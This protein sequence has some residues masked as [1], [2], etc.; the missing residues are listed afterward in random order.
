MKVT[1]ELDAYK[2]FALDTMVVLVFPRVVAGTIV[3]P[4]LTL[5]SI[6]LAV[7]G[8]F[9]P[10]IPE[11]YTFKAY[12]AGV[13]ESVAMND[14]GQAL[15][16]GVVFGAIFAGLGCYHGLRTGS[17][18]DAVGRSTTRAVVSGIVAILV[19]DSIISGIFYT[20]TT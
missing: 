7:V 3:L 18:A 20:L 16:K 8:G 4:L 10:L 9:I 15:V 12:L 14:L 19:A 1:E 2:T 5:Y 13:V 11:G 6:L 17:G